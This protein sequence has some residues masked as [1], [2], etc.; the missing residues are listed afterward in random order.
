MI[1]PRK[2]RWLQD[3]SSGRTSSSWKTKTWNQETS[4]QSPSLPVCLYFRVWI[5]HGDLSLG[6]SPG[7]QTLVPFWVP[8]SKEGLPS[9]G[10][11]VPP[12]DIPLL[13]HSSFKD[14]Y[15]A[16]PPAATQKSNSC[17]R[18]SSAIE[19]L[20]LI[21]FPQILPLG[22]DIF[23]HRLEICALS[24]FIHLFIQQ[25]F[26]NLLCVGNVAQTQEGT[27]MNNSSPSFSKAFAAFWGRKAYE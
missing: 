19:N 6:A 18:L 23:L 11:T 16:S 25:L 21:H 24:S 2:H 22:F 4:F 1:S 14:V 10:L 9:V 3:S 20:S 7:L 15:L 13:C 27:K 17:P 12:L 26:S 5:A 8:P